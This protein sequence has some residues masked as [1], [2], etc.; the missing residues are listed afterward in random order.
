MADKLKKMKEGCDR[1]GGKAGGNM[2]LYPWTKP[3][4]SQSTAGT[5]LSEQPCAFSRSK[6]RGRELNYVISFRVNYFP[7]CDTLIPVVMPHLARTLLQELNYSCRQRDAAQ[8]S[9]CRHIIDL[10]WNA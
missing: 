6:Q 8:V 2:L 7:S 1:R 9:F 5:K 3:G 10:P 4:T